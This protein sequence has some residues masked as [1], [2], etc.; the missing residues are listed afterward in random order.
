MYLILSLKNTK[1]SEEQITLWRQNNAGYTLYLESAGKYESYEPGYHDSE[2][3]MPISQDLLNKLDKGQ[4][5]NDF[6]EPVSFILNSKK[7]RDT[8]NLHI[9]KGYLCRK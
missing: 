5:L 2:S 3:A 8:L 9:V 4:T 1:K 6:G 7:N